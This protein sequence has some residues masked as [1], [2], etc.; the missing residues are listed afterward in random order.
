M[1]V[2]MVTSS[3]VCTPTVFAKENS[4]DGEVTVCHDGKQ[5]S[6]IVVPQN[7][8]TELDASGSAYVRCKIHKFT[9]PCRVIKLC[10]AVF[11]LK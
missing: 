4:L 9:P 10:R 8:R 1:A 11:I 6:N 3:A 5:T 7:E 2:M